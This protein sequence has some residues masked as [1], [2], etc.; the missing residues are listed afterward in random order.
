MEE[1]EDAWDL[2]CALQSQWRVSGFGIVGLDYSQ[3]WPVAEMLEIEVTPDVF[4][5]IRMLEAEELKEQAEKPQKENRDDKNKPGDK[6][7]KKA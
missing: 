3:I 7:R 6:R 1:N 2:Y 5:K 4:R